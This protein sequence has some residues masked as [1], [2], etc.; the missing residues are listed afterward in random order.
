MYYFAEDQFDTAKNNAVLKIHQLL[1]LSTSYSENVLTFN[2]KAAS[3]YRGFGNGVFKYPY[4]FSAYNQVSNTQLLSP[5]KGMLE[6]GTAELFSISSRDST[7]VA[8]IINGEFTDVPRKNRSGNFE[9]NFS[10]PPGL[11]ELNI[12]GSRDGRSYT[13]LIKYNRTAGSLV[14]IHPLDQFPFPCYFTLQE[15]RG[16]IAEHAMPEIKPV[17]PDPDNAGGGSIT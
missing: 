9:L 14:S 6:S 7:K 8:I 17:E 5:V 1:E 13:G 3:A 11:T 2:I 4:T 12:F 15:H 16:G 10:I